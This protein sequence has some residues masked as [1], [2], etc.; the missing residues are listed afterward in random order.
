MFQLLLCLTELITLLLMLV[1][2]TVLYK[3]ARYFVL[4]AGRL[5]SLRY[6]NGHAI[7]DYVYWVYLYNLYI[8]A[9]SLVC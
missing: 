9:L 8:Y 4:Q 1:T 7:F 3:I 2:T 6:Q 5:N